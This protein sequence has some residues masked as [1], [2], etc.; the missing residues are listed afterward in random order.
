VRQGDGHAQTARKAADARDAAERLAVRVP[1]LTAALSAAKAGV[2]LARFE[3]AGV[4][5]VARRNLR[6]RAMRHYEQA[7]LRAAEALALLRAM[8]AK[9]GIGEDWA[10]FDAAAATI[11][12]PAL[13]SARESTVP[14][15]DQHWKA[16]LVGRESAI[17]TKLIADASKRLDADMRRALAG[18]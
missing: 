3:L 7:A 17:L 13:R 8:S 1:E 6:D 11:H 15:E 2:G 10:E 5:G 16:T 12:I 14:V 18:E 9:P 4:T